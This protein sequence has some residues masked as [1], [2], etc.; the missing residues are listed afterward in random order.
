MAVD[1]YRMLTIIVVVDNDL[2]QIPV[3]QNVRISISPIDLRAGGVI[4]TR[5]SCDN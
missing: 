1:V 3:T 5:Q 4:A 2:D